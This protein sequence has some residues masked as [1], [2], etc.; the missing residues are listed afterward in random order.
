MPTSVDI[1]RICIPS[2]LPSFEEK[3]MFRRGYSSI[4]PDDEVV[5]KPTAVK[6]Q[7]RQEQFA[8]VYLKLAQ[9]VV[10]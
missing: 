5:G 1:E 9:K 7:R 2:I 4:R 3:N 6:E 10:N 8:Q